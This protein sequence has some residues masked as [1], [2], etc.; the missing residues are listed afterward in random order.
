MEFLDDHENNGVTV[1][2]LIE[3]VSEDYPHSFMVVADDVSISQSDHPLLI[4]DLL[5]VRGRRFRS[6][7]AQVP[8]VENN[9]SI[10]NMGFEEFA[11]AVDEG[12]VF[13]GLS[14]M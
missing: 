7:P 5:E 3:M 6:L 12:G 4:V 13:R 14:N 8:S 2:Q 10:G 1:E 11:N 9:L